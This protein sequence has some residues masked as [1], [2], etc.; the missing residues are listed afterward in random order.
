M[1]QPTANIVMLP[2]R[3]RVGE[4]IREAVWQLNPGQLLTVAGNLI[5]MANDAAE[6]E[7]DIDFYD[8]VR[9]AHLCLERIVIERSAT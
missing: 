5:R 3:E 2:V 4:P 1:S 6:R 8:N 7:D 9:A